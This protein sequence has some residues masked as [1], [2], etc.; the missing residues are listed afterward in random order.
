MS[1]GS[2]QPP[3]DFLNDPDAEVVLRFEA[4]GLA[5]ITAAKK[6]AGLPRRKASPGVLLSAARAAQTAGRFAE[7]TRKYEEAVELQPEDPT[8]L[9]GYAWFLVTVEDKKHRN[10]KRAV[11]IARRA[12][13]LTDERSGHILD[14]LA[15]ALHQAGKLEEAV[16]Y[17][18]AAAKLMQHPEIRARA[19]RFRK[20]LE[21]KRSGEVP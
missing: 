20:E 10:P 11:E 1:G 12:V 6:L 17:A 21:K 4:P 9:N 19:Q 7:A 5:T 16:K 13:E 2:C 14:T 8:L 15:E 3:Q 18:T